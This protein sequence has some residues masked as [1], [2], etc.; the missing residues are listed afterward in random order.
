[1]DDLAVRHDDAI[2]ERIGVQIEQQPAFD[3]KR[4]AG[5]GYRDQQPVARFGLEI[6]ERRRIESRDLRQFADDLLPI[7]TALLELLV[8]IEEIGDHFL[9]VTDEHQIEEVGQRFDVEHHRPAGDHQRMLATA[10][11]AAQRD[12]GEIEQSP[13]RWSSSFRT[14]ARTRRCRARP[15]AWRSPGW[16][17]AA[18]AVVTRHPCRARDRTRARRRCPHGR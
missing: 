11:A 2:R 14:A 13:T 5:S 18:A 8:A 10:L 17:A 16:S 12:A 7:R 9:A 3:R 6:V 1:M 4:R 15:V